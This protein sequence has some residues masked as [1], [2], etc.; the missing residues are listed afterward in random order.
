MKKFIITLFMV[1]NILLFANENP[2]SDV[3]AA[4][5]NSNPEITI[6]ASIKSS[7]LPKLLSEYSPVSDPSLFREKIFYLENH[8]SMSELSKILH[9]V[10]TMKGIQY[11]STGEKKWE[12]L[13]SE[14]TFIDSPETKNPVGKSDYCLL[15]DHSLGTC[16]YKLTYFEKADEIAVNFFLVEPIKLG[17]V[18]AVKP[19]NLVINLLVS[20]NPD[21]N[22]L[23]LYMNVKAKY[24]KLSLIEKRLNK[25]F[26][27]RIDSMYTWFKDQISK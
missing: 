8:K 13:Y 2:V 15:E 26:E 7:I 4:A 9:S 19:E 20:K 18:K 16:I 27:R 6:S 5:E 23:T 21:S 24:V 3:V 25:S 1:M 11:Y 12:T 22:N 10:S 17:P 14:A